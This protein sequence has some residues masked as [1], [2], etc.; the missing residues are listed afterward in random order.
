[1]EEVKEEERS[2]AWIEMVGG[3]KWMQGSKLVDG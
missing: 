1:M 2:N 3:E